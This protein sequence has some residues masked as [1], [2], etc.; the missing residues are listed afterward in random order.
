MST[1]AIDAIAAMLCG[2][3]KTEDQN[4]NARLLRLHRTYFPAMEQSDI[5]WV[6]GRLEGYQ[7]DVRHL[8][9]LL[10]MS[11][12]RESNDSYRE[13]LRSSELPSVLP[14][15]TIMKATF[16]AP[17]MHA[18]SIP[19]QAIREMPKG[20]QTLLSAPE[21][22]PV[23]VFAGRVF[24]DEVTDGLASSY[25]INHL[26]WIGRNVK[27]L[28]PFTTNFRNIRSVDRDVCDTL[29]QG[30]SSLSSGVL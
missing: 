26:D 28:L 12:E 23:E 3:L 16:A 11:T 15:H 25:D 1:E 5:E 17:V 22:E 29:L 19:V 18:L 6:L 20:V 30:H 27:R 24:T 21:D 4:I 2:Q 14:P 10:L 7:P 13:W 8:L 9:A